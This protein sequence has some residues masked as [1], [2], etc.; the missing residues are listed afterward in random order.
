MN[1]DRV[2]IQ[3][4][5]GAARRRVWGVSRAGAGV[6][7]AWFDHGAASMSASVAF[8]AAFSLAPLLVV[9]MAVASF[10]FGAEAVQ[11]RLFSEIESVVGGQGAQAVQ[12]MVA[13]AWMT[14]D[15]GWSGILSL[16]AMVVGATATFAELNRSL[17]VIWGAPPSKHAMAGL[18]RVRLMS[19]GIVVGTGF[20]VVVLLIA[21]ALL[22]YVGELLW[23]QWRVFPLLQWL[24][25]ASAF[26][27][28]WLAFTAL[29]KVLPDVP[30]RWR[31]AAEGGLAAAVLFSLGKH[32]FARYLAY[33][34]TANAFG[35]A[36]SLA[37]L[38]MWLFFSSAVFLVGAEV[39]AAASRRHSSGQKY[40][41]V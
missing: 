27:F 31:M 28:L 35:A 15:G 4:V 20:L 37:V 18:L 32:L 25:Q 17:N 23:S 16:G 21:D 39:A 30:V 9:A 24:Q 26:L 6:V 19:F 34:G 11:G 22:V 13:S 36:G 40:T 12:A 10:F 5:L 41:P 14:G 1:A 3:H 29:L 8:Y 38:M 33:V 2:R 7:A